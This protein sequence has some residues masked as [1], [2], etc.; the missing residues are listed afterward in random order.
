MGSYVEHNLIAGEQIVY[1]T[2]VHPIV[3]ATP[4]ALSSAALSSVP[5]AWR[6]RARSS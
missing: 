5:W 3:F 2:K 4:S 1:Q 6:P